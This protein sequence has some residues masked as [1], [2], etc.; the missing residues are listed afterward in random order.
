LRAG[1]E[2]PKLSD[3]RARRCDTVKTMT[4]EQ[5][6]LMAAIRR[7]NVNGHRPSSAEA[8]A[9]A[10]LPHTDSNA[11]QALVSGLKNDL[12]L[13][14]GYRQGEDFGWRELWLL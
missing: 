7:L 5:T 9:A 12:R 14:D 8:F 1:R 10:A 3:T 6:A 2:V 13:I 11:I 4:P